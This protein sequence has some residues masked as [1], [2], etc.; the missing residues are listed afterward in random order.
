MFFNSLLV[1]FVIKTVAFSVTGYAIARNRCG[2]SATFTFVCLGSGWGNGCGRCFLLFKPR[3]KFFGGKMLG[4]IAAILFVADNN[5]S[6]I[7]ADNLGILE[8]VTDFQFEHFAL[9]GHGGSLA[10]LL[11]GRFLCGCCGRRCLRTSWRHLRVDLCRYLLF[12]IGNLLQDVVAVDQLAVALLI[13]DNVCAALAVLVDDGVFG[14]QTSSGVNIIGSKGKTF[15][16]FRVLRLLAVHA[17][18]AAVRYERVEVVGKHVV[19]KHGVH[20]I[21]DIKRD[22][23]KFADSDHLGLASSHVAH[24][25]LVAVSAWLNVHA[26]LST[27]NRSVKV[28]DGVPCAVLITELTAVNLAVRIAHFLDYIIRTTLRHFPCDRLIVVSAEFVKVAVEVA[29]VSLYGLPFCIV[30]FPS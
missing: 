11:H 21:T 30:A 10:L 5:A 20:F 8:L 6:I 24:H 29:V 9:F 15:T 16:F 7:F 22:L 19:L 1:E 23:R 25:H 14:A 27:L 17:C 2:G 18:P 26:S 4:L 13:L 3:C 28:N 12:R